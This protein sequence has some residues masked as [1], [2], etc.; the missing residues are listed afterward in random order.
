[1]L[2]KPIIILPLKELLIDIEKR[3]FPVEKEYNY[4]YEIQYQ[5]EIPNEYK[6]EFLPD[7]Y[8]NETDFAS[9]DIQYTVQKNSIIVT[10]K[11]ASKTLLL[12]KSDFEKWNTFIKALNKQYNQSLILSK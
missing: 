11:V 7:N 4:L 10:Q 1:M 12:Q 3:K 9:V 6:V 8:K 2:L 5:Y